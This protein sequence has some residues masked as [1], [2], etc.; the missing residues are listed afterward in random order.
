MSHNAY[1]RT[2]RKARESPG[3]G[4]HSDIVGGHLSPLVIRHHAGNRMLDNARPVDGVRLVQASA[5]YSTGYSTTPLSDGAT[6]RRTGNREA[7]SSV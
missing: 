7:L 5:G 6:S 1:S 4:A 3:R 2:R